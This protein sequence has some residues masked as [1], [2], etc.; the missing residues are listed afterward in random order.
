[1]ND[2]TPCARAAHPDNNREW[3]RRP[4]L[5]LTLLILVAALGCG[6]EDS[7]KRHGASQRDLDEAGKIVE[8]IPSEE[9]LWQVDPF[10]G[11][12]WPGMDGAEDS[13]NAGERP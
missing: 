12:P 1:M 9:A 11:L 4:V 10:S 5:L 6:C 8:T 2:R 7:I 3:L 13:G